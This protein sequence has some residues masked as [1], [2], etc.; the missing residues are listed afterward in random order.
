MEI[1]SFYWYSYW[2]YCL[3]WLSFRPRSHCPSLR[4]RFIL[5]WWS[6]MNR[7][8]PCHN[9]GGTVDNL[10]DPGWTV[11]NRLMSPVVLKCLKQPGVT[12]KAVKYRGK[13]G[14]RREQPCVHRDGVGAI[15]AHSGYIRVSTVINRARRRPSVCLIFQQCGLCQQQY[16]RSACA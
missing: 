12:G 4:C 15:P 11:L 14:R 5:V 1:G 10:G 6:G 8:E 7:G 3:C 13:P 16:L 2:K 9:R